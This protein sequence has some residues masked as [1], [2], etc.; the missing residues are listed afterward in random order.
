MNI[1]DLHAHPQ[2]KRQI[3]LYACNNPKEL[4]FHCNYCT[5]ETKYVPC[6]MHVWIAYIYISIYYMMILYDIL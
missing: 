4:R 2:T 1:Q 5:E 3:S 6:T